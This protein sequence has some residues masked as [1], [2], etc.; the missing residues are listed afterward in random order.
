MS[1]KLIKSLFFM[2][3]VEVAHVAQL[4][5]LEQHEQ[6]EKRPSGT[7]VTSSLGADRPA[8]PAHASGKMGPE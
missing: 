6:Q 7:T 1:N 3:F 5:R 8:L 2:G 4:D